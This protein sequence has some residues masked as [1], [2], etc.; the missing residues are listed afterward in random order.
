M[1]YFPLSFT[2]MHY[3]FEL[4]GKDSRVES[5]MGSPQLMAIYSARIMADCYQIELINFN[6]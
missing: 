5:L 6:H 1:S 3:P 2:L 4:S